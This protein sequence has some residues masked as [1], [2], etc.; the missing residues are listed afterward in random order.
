MAVYLGQIL[1]NLQKKILIADLTESEGLHYLF[2][3]S[4]QFPITY[5]NVDYIDKHFQI[6]AKENETYDYI[7]VCMRHSGDLP[8]AHCLTKN[9]Y[10][11]D[12]EYEHLKMMLDEIKNAKTVTGIIIRDIPARKFSVEYLFRCVFMDEYVMKMCETDRIYRIRSDETDRQYRLDMQYGVFENFKELSPDYQRVL[13]KL[14]VELTGC[15]QKEA[16]KLVKCAKEGK[17]SA[18]YHI[19]EQYS[20]EKRNKR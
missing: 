15:P 20:G 18:K 19:L 2:S 10:I 1:K 16:A 7:F 12:T 8:M 5:Q 11:S 3:A 17:N 14:A 6:T 9:Y 13:E 4:E